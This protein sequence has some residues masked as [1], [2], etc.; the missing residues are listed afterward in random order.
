MYLYGTKTPLLL[1]K[2]KTHRYVAVQYVVRPPSARSG[3][4][5][6]VNDREHDGVKT[7]PHD[8]PIMSRVKANKGCGILV[9]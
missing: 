8:L 7:T 9:N 4:A 6:D 3:G 2:G 5:A 1:A